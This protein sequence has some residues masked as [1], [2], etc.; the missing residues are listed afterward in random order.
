MELGLN[1]DIPPE[2]LLPVLPLPVPE[3]ELLLLWLFGSKLDD[4]V[5]DPVPLAPPVI[6]AFPPLLIAEDPAIIPEAPVITDAASA[7]FK[8]L[9][10]PAPVRFLIEQYT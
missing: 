10:P 8:E 2:S 5:P 9:F 1:I 6:T 4:P 7:P 3:L